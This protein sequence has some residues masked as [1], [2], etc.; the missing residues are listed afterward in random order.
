MEPAMHSGRK[1]SRRSN[2][3]TRTAESQLVKGERFDYNL[4]VFYEPTYM[5][6]GKDGD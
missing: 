6:K 5:I 2:D 4:R 1:I 3:K